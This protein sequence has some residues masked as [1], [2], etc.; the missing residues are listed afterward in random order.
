[1]PRQPAA[2]AACAGRL[3]AALVAVVAIG[4]A[5]ASE[6]EAEPIP[7]TLPVLTT[8]PPQLT[9]TTLPPPSATICYY[10]VQP[11][12][13]LSLIARRFEISVEALMEE[14]GLDDT[15]IHPGNDL[16]IPTSPHC[17]DLSQ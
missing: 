7:T 8:L 5:C 6:P 13:T 12:N 10:T 11:G 2:G 15:V 17:P 1:M 9:T 14:N 4:G 16:V 3:A